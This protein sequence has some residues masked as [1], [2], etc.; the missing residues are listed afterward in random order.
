MIAGALAISA[1]L[2]A[3][4]VTAYVPS[5]PLECIKID[6]ELSL[7]AELRP[8]TVLSCNYDKKT[9][10]QRSLSML[11]LPERSLS[12]EAVERVFSFSELTTLY[13]HSRHASYMVRV[14]GRDGSWEATLSFSEAFYPTDA[15][16]RPR[17]RPGKRP[18]LLR[19]GIHGD[20]KFS[21]TFLSRLSEKRQLNCT[22]SDDEVVRFARR[23]GW[24]IEKMWLLPT[25]G[26]PPILTTTLRRGRSSA[27][28]DIDSSGCVTGL[29]LD[30]SADRR[31]N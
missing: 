22:L 10:F 23:N 11:A 2:M 24:Q 4:G 28:N 30:R 29:T 26:V 3:G 18:K 8:V 15:W 13:D 14:K 7:S 21:V 9:I 12:I 20:T 31:A 27:G 5:A 6:E 17:F 25:D 19:P 1:H 16:R